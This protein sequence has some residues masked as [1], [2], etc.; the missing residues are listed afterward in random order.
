MKERICHQEG[1]G[2]E[3]VFSKHI[4]FFHFAISSFSCLHMMFRCLNSFFF[5]YRGDLIR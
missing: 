4:N 3:P 2:S 5:G 1:G